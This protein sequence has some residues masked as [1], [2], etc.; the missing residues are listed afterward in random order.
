MRQRASEHAH[1]HAAVYLKRD[2]GDVGGLRRGDEDD[3]RGIFLGLAV[4]AQGDHRGLVAFAHLIG[5]RALPS[6]RVGVELD[7]PIGRDAPGLDG[8]HADSVLREVRRQRLQHSVHRRA[9][10]VRQDEVQVLRRLADARRGRVDDRPAALLAHLGKDEPREPYCGEEREVDGLVPRGVVEVIESPGLRSAGVDDENVDRPKPALRELYER[11]AAFSSRYVGGDRQ[12]VL[13]PGLAL[14]LPR[15]GADGAFLA[16][17]HRDLRFLPCEL[18][19]DG[20]TKTLARRRDQDDF[21]GEAEI[22]A[23]IVPRCGLGA[24]YGASTPTRIAMTMTAASTR[25]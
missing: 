5:G 14:D 13:V 6:R 16:A 15:R 4:A 10:G 24:T 20:A 1:E 21:S 17:A 8:V 23:A 19:G 12:Q 18:L 11:L 3:R 22:D 9:Y 2:P 25:R 7:E